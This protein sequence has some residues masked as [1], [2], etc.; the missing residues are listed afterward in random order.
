VWVCV[1]V[2]GGCGC[3]LSALVSWAGLVPHSSSQLCCS[4]AA[5][6]APSPQHATHHAHERA[7]TS[8][9]ARQSNT[10]LTSTCSLWLKPSARSSSPDSPS[11]LAD[12]CRPATSVQRRARARW[13]AMGWGAMGHVCADASVRWLCE[14]VLSSAP[15]R[16]AAAAPS[17]S[18]PAPPPRGPLT[19]Q[20]GVLCVCLLHEPQPQRTQHRGRRRGGC[21]WA[22]EAEEGQRA[23]LAVADSQLVPEAQA[24]GSVCGRGPLRRGCG[25][26]VCVCG[27]ERG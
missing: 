15:W 9:R 14:G 10:R 18:R 12:Q 23:W 16:H 17:V 1:W 3:V 27:G 2:C 22:A 7:R 8:H 25:V 21:Y 5:R 4:V 6:T 19:R 13:A 20:V 26:C 24:C 11:G